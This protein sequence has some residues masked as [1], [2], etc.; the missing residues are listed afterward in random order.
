MIDLEVYREHTTQLTYFLFSSSSQSGHFIQSG[1]RVAASLSARVVIPGMNWSGFLS[2]HTKEDPVP[3]SRPV[4][5][6]PEYSNFISL[7]HSVRPAM[8]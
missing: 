6:K 5:R 8:V 3:A 7:G 1:T 2:R 4:V